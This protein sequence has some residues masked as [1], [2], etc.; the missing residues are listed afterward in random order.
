[1]LLTVAI[2][3]VLCLIVFAAVV[4]GLAWAIRSP[5]PRPMPR[6]VGIRT[7]ASSHRRVASRPA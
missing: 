4:G 6:V 5:A 1:M 2:N 3:V 7:R